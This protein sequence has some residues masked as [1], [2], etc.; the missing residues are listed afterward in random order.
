MLLVLGFFVVEGDQGA[1]LIAVGIALGSLGGLELTIR[2]HFAGFRSHTLCW[3]GWPRPIVLGPLLPR[4]RGAAARVAQ[5][6]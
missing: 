6:R 1:V 4:P 2:E 5:G 3:R